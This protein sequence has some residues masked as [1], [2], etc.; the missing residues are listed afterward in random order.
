MHRALLLLMTIG[1]NTLLMAQKPHGTT[2]K[3]RAGFSLGI[4]HSLLQSNKGLSENMMIHNDIGFQ[5]DMMVEYVLNDRMLINSAFGFSLND[6]KVLSGTH[7]LPYDVFGLSADFMIHG[8]Y[9]FSTSA[10]RPYILIGPSL[11]W[12]MDIDRNYS[13]QYP[14]GKNLAADIGFGLEKV[15][16]F[17]SIS[18]EL[19]YSWGL[20]NV[21]ANPALI[22]LTYHRVSFSFKFKG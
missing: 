1:L 21:N 9:R 18:P 7:E 17:L 15:F 5:M 19:R 3:V 4:N 11:M 14:A 2:E 16:G 20:S 12:P 8:I 13:A 6:S 10:F 22:S